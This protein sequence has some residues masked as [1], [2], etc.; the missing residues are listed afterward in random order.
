MLASLLKCCGLSRF[1]L[2]DCCVNVV[3]DFGGEYLVEMQMVQ[4]TCST[5][6]SIA[7]GVGNKEY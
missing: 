7:I 6:G 5:R 1:G 2:E 4:A 3:L